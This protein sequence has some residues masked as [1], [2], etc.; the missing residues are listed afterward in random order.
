MNTSV[1]E[2]EAQLDVEPDDPSQ[3]REPAARTATSDTRSERDV[4]VDGG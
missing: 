3:S 2:G 1:R 4:V